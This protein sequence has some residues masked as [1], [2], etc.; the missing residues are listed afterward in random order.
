MGGAGLPGWGDKKMYRMRHAARGTRHAPCGMR[1][2]ACGMWGTKTTSEEAESADWHL[3]KYTQLSTLK[4][5]VVYVLLH[6][7]PRESSMSRRL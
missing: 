6:G 1:H 4:V 3:Q 5:E 7:E 2:A